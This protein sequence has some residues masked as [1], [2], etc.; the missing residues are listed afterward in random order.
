MNSKSSRSPYF[1]WSLVFILGG[2]IWSPSSKCATHWRLGEDGEVNAIY[3]EMEDVWEKDP[4]FHILA[5]SSSNFE[6]PSKDGENSSSDMIF[7]PNELNMQ[8]YEDDD[9]ESNKS[10]ESANS[11]YSYIFVVFYNLK[12]CLKRL[13]N[14]RWYEFIYI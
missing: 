13:N 5:T 9:E 6:K 4:L 2:C 8:G 1:S 11:K 12:K 10:D 14:F 3:N 7:L